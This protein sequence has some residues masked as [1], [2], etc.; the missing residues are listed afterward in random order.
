MKRRSL[1]EI[2]DGVNVNEAETQ[3][4]QFYKD[5]KDKDPVE[6]DATDEDDAMEKIKTITKRDPKKTTF[7]RKTKPGEKP[8]MEADDEDEDDEDRYSVFD[9][10]EWD[11]R[12]QDDDEDSE[13]YPED[14]EPQEEDIVISDC[15]GLGAKTCV[16]IVGGKFLG[17]FED[18][19]EAYDYI[20]KWM[21]KNQF[22]P[23]VWYVS[24]HGN[25]SVVNINEENTTS[26]L[27]G[28]EGPPRTPL[29][30]QR[31]KP[32]RS[33]KRKEYQNATS[34]TGFGIVGK[35]RGDSKYST[36]LEVMQ[37]RVNKIISESMVVGIGAV[38]VMRELKA[39]TTPE[40]HQ[41]QIALKT[42]KM[43]PGMAT[44]MGGMSVDEAVAF[45]KRIG[46]TA[47]EINKLAGENITELKKSVVPGE[48][49]VYVQT[50]AFKKTIVTVAPSYAAAKK[51]LKNLP[52]DPKYG[53]YDGWG[54]TNRADWETEEGPITTRESVR[55]SKYSDW[56]SDNTASP[57]QKINQSIQEVNR[58]LYEIE[59]M[60]NR[61]M[62]LK[63]ESGL[64]SDVYWKQTLGRF[65]KISERLLR[66]GNKLRELNK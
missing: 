63:T 14:N 1:V 37:R 33:D 24:D 35:P 52:N 5:D 47:Q 65:S 25:A 27:D 4:Y 55:E 43:T 22:W 18:G 9:Q 54:M 59:T 12:F 36:K 11:R 66:V 51:V 17:E 42:L 56:A 23:T 41:E 8:V 40:K 45:L 39:H 53:D 61:V 29:A 21:E 20:R 38:G 19:D 2:I 30:F 58:K 34:S 46:Y 48:W 60:V 3:T 16:S 13:E 62:K 15:G 49:V 10:D 44:V 26:N 64:E 57:K 50:G 31:S 7:W 6:I 28:G 32:T